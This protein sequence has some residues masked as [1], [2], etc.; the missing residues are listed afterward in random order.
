MTFSV[1]YSYNVTWKFEPNL[2]NQSWKHNLCVNLRLGKT[3]LGPQAHVDITIQ[4]KIS[5]HKVTKTNLLLNKLLSGLYPNPAF[6]LSVQHEKHT[7]T[8]AFLTIPIMICS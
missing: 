2:K 1:F 8:S 7:R 6:T 5:L 4:H 3:Q